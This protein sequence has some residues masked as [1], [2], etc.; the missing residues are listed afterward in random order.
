[1]TTNKSI[2]TL[3][4]VAMVCLFAM[5]LQAGKITGFSWTN[6]II[7]IAGITPPASVTVNND[8]VSGDSPN[9]LQILQKD[10]GTVGYIDIEFTVM[11]TG[12]V[13]EYA[14]IE[15]VQNSSGLD[16]ASYHVQLGFGTGS[17]FEISDPGDDLDFDAP[18]YNSTIQFDPSLL[19]SFPT[20]TMSEDVLVASG[21]PGQLN[22]QYNEPFV[23]HI[24]VPDGITTFTLR[25]FPVAVI[26]EPTSVALL[27]LAS[28]SMVA[29]RR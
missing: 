6:G 24:D 25:Q 26:P 27:L 11:D 3:G 28:L 5:P 14:I 20:V 10:F 9:E 29:I 16:W 4:A 1:M 21:G 18:F 23:Y 12:G 19:F 13:T 22:G 17:G 2:T 7:S 15:G 8:D